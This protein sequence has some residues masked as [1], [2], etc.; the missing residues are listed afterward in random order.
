METLVMK[1]AKFAAK[2]HAGQFRKDGLTPAIAHP[3]RVAGRVAVL[4]FATEEL[5]AVAYLHDVLED[6]PVTV[7]ELEELFGLE[8][9]RLVEFLTKKKTEGNREA[10][11]SRYFQTLGEAPAVV[12]AVKALDR[13]DNLRD[14]ALLPGHGEFAKEY[15]AETHR[16]SL[17]IPEAGRDLLEEMRRTAQGVLNTVTAG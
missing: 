7:G 9:A 11:L 17:F 6:C 5:V 12:H 2:A 8:V 13:I 1:A 16:L 4:P 15:V 10:R 3:A 14:L